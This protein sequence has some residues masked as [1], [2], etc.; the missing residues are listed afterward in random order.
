MWRQCFSRSAH[1]RRCS[2]GMDKTLITL[3][4]QIPTELH[5]QLRHIALDHDAT[6]QEVVTDAVLLFL[7]FH[8]RG[9]DLPGPA[10]LPLD[11][12]GKGALA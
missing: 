7:R 6:V 8:G 11:T 1:A 12:T 10:L 5:R 2:R 4:T 3:R 9:H